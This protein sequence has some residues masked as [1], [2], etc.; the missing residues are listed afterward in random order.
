MRVAIAYLV[1]RNRAS[2]LDDPETRGLGGSLVVASAPP[3]RPGSA[4][5]RWTSRAGSRPSRKGLAIEGPFF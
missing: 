4:S 2:S 1:Q 3:T 5:S